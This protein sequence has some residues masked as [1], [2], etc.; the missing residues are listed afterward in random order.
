MKIGFVKP[1]EK[2]EQEPE[3]GY[4]DTAEPEGEDKDRL[5]DW[6]PTALLYFTMVYGVVAV[7]RDTIILLRRD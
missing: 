2:N 5:F 1:D 6:V 3:R 4:A 7:V